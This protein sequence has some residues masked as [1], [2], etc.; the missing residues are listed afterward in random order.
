MLAVNRG[1]NRGQ[2]G[3]IS[4]DQSETGIVKS[5]ILRIRLGGDQTACCVKID[6]DPI[7]TPLS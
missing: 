5:A 3:V 1:Y 2:S 6:V 4:A 7:F